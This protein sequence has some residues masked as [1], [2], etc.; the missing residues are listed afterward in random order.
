ML[1]VVVGAKGA[2][3]PP[4]V[5]QYAEEKGRMSCE[6][7]IEDLA[8]R[9]EEF[10]ISHF[11]KKLEFAMKDRTKLS[12]RAEA[13][14]VEAQKRFANLVPDV[15]RRIAPELKRTEAAYLAELE[16]VMQQEP[17]ALA[18]LETFTEKFN[19][20]PF[21]S[22]GQKVEVVLA[23]AFTEDGE[24]FQHE[25]LDRLSDR[26]LLRAQNLDKKADSDGQVTVRLFFEQ[27]DAEADY[28]Q[29]FT[30]ELKVDRRSVYGG[31]PSLVQP[32]PE[33]ILPTSLEALFA[34]Y[35]LA[36]ATLPGLSK[37]MDE[38]VHSIEAGME[39][40]TET[41]VAIELMHAPLK[42]YERAACKAAEKYNLC[43]DRLLD[44]ARCT[45]VC[46]NLSEVLAVLSAIEASA[47]L[48]I[49]RM[50]NRINPLFPADESAGYRDVLLN[51]VYI[52]TGCVCEVQVTLSAFVHI[53][54]TG[55]H[56]AYKV[57]RAIGSDSAQRTTYAGGLKD[58][59]MRQV[60]A[61][62]TLR[63][64]LEG[65]TV[66]SKLLN[67]F[68]GPECLAAPAI[69]LRE[70]C[71]GACTGLKDVEL[72]RILS[73]DV[74]AALG[75]TIR[76]ID[77]SATGVKGKLG[78]ISYVAE[79]CTRLEALMLANNNVEGPIPVCISQI[80]RLQTL[81]LASNPMKCSIPPELGQLEKLVVLELHDCE[82]KG[83]IPQSL[84]K[85]S[86]LQ[87]LAIND[88]E[89][90]G[91]IPSELCKL[92]RLR[93]LYVCG[94]ELT[95]EIPMEFAELPHL[96]TIHLGGNELSNMEAFR[97]TVTANNP[98]CACSI[99]VEP[100]DSPREAG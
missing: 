20:G 8:E 3:G 67:G 97:S 52:E 100:E 82:L 90:E 15:A 1:A 32:L 7:A 56:W 83:C 11:M 89:L 14:V 53:K 36:G 45:V 74:C 96:T 76:I 16:V 50:K 55:G 43:F 92:K 68:L 18:E 62:L 44:I 95:G 5:M 65:T 34:V 42:A 91:E 61:G 79:Q 66:P 59:I 57:G 27:M 87:V 54:K 37:A 6:K 84:G 10:L 85:L 48:R 26:S 58:I 78:D 9:E 31:Q 29:E 72:G 35:E 41:P 23:G 38:V 64:L 93:A 75:T 69:R 24:F 22:V 88:N 71:M 33:G 60:G 17:E 49:V 98:M 12:E 19:E 86:R 40:Q 73:E 81:K 21:K 99:V 46:T 63:L 77:L 2:I 51:V 94:N 47:S 13:E 80:S 28:K 70:L 39:E 30:T 4:V 25:I